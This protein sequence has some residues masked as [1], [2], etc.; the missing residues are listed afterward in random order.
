MFVEL[1]DD[2]RAD[3][4]KFGQIVGGATR[5]GQELELFG[6]DFGLGRR[7]LRF[8]GLRQRFGDR[9]HSLAEIDPLRALAPRNT[10]DRRARNEIAIEL[11]G[12]AG[13]VVGRDRKANAVRIAVGVEDRDHGNLEAIGLLDR[14]RFLV[15]V[16]HEHKVGNAAHV[17]D[18][19]ERRLELFAFARQHEALLLGQAFR[20]LAQELVHFAQA[21]DRRRNRLPVGQH[22][23]EPAR[24]DKILRR[25]PGGSRDLIRRLA[26]GADEKHPAALRDGIGDRLQRLMQQRHGLGEVD[27]VDRVARAVDIRRHLRVPAMRLVAEMRARLEQLTHGEIWQSHGTLILVRLSLGGSCEAKRASPP[28]RNLGSGAA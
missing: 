19:A 8:D 17:L 18:A 11:D 16:D 1:L 27:D 9:R 25:A 4:G 26:L 12:A 2:L 28:E 21:R 22:A 10:V 14:Q 5:G 15:G 3:A 20:A 13:V 6:Q 7:G 23:A 24:V